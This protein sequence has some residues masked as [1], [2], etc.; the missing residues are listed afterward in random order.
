[1]YQK[2]IT[3]LSS[4]SD[5]V[6][7]FTGGMIIC[8]VCSVFLPAWMAFSLAAVAGVAKEIRDEISYGGFDWIDLA[9]TVAGGALVFGCIILM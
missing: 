6:W 9:A 5:K 7:H 4:N 3:W 2:L 8:L 1:M